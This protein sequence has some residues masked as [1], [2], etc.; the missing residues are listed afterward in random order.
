MNAR[1]PRSQEDGREVKEN[2]SLNSFSFFSWR[3]GVLAFI[4]LLSLLGAA[5]APMQKSDDFKGEHTED[6]LKTARPDKQ[7]SDLTAGVAPKLPHIGTGG[8]DVPLRNLIDEHLFGA[9][10]EAKVPHAP[11]SADDEFC[12]RVHLDLTGRIPTPEKL[13]AFVDD[14]DPE[15]RDKLIDDL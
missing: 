15:K 4:P 10:R 12:R 1:T 3:L 6:K 7:V 14:K 11:L 13:R 2:V 5:P 8:H 9:M